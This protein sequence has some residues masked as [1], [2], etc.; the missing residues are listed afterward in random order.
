MVTI[1]NEYQ[2]LQHKAEVD[3]HELKTPLVAILAYARMYLD[4]KDLP[5][6]FKPGLKIIYKNARRQEKIVDDLLSNSKLEAGEMKLQMTYLNLIP[7]LRQAVT[8]F[9]L[10][11]K[12]KGIQ[13]K[14]NLPRSL[15]SINAD[16]QRL[17]QVINNLISN[18]LKFT[19][20]GS[21]TLAAKV[22]NNEIKI[23]LTDTGMGIKQEDIPR[24]F[25]KFV[26]TQDNTTRKTRRT[27][28]GLAICKEIVSAH[29]GKIW[30]ES[31]GV[32]K[33][34]TFFFTLPTETVS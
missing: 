25:T 6:K 14:F 5:E 16:G 20:K 17:T 10:E 33:G 1:S 21:I 19:R 13:L 31:K 4:N 2:A 9:S 24:L 12:E 15:P 3:A 29:H 27:G 11:A 28:L 23:Y 8:G 26:H 22:I 18:S 32:G 34:S 7:V 30:V